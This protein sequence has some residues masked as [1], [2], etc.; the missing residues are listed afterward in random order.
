[1]DNDVAVFL[2]LDNILIG[3]IEVNLSFDIDLLLDHIKELTGGRLVLRRAYGDW[4]QRANMTKQLAASGF[5]L[6]STV[7]LGAN[8]KN[9][10]DMQMVVDA[11]STLVDG[12]DFSTYVLITGD[13]DF[14]PLVQAL[15]KRGKRVIGAGL[16]HATSQRLAQLCDEFIYYDQLAAEANEAL[17]GQLV[18]LIQRALDQLLQD[19]ERVPASLLRQRVQALSKGS[20]SR[21]PQGKRSFAK[22]LVD[23]PDVAHLEQE[24]T[25]LYVRRPIPGSSQALIEDRIAKHLPEEEVRELLRL[26][27][28]NLLR[29]HT[30]VRASL[31]KQQMQDLSN[32]AF[33]ETLQGDKSF[34]R[35][36]ERFPD[37]VRVEQ[38]GSTLYVRQTN[39]GDTSGPVAVGRIVSAS[40]AKNLLAQALDDLLVDQARVRA[41][42]LKQHMQELS[43]GAF[44]ENRLGN[45]TFRQFLDGYSDLVESQQKGTTLLV[46]RPQNYLKPDELHLRYRGALKKKGLRVVPSNIRLPLLKDI[47]A[48]LKRYPQLQWRLLVDQLTGYYLKSGQ[49]EISKSFV[50]DL[51]RVARRAGIINV[52]NGSSL[53]KSPVALQITG[54]RSFQDSVIKTDLVYLREIKNLSDPFDLEQAS[55]ALYEDV[56]HTRY[57]Q[58][59][60]NRFTDKSEEPS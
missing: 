15:R 58:V 22:L 60:L 51:L 2:D 20:F 31:L 13:R 19:Q 1:M 29:D 47:I 25:T 21:S 11:M 27:L 28:A 52:K 3:V 17:D 6:Q 14:A 38:E 43:D 42:L 44:D 53:A 23:F 9:L 12:Q 56:G 45:D 5:E 30:Q 57:L 24:G 35:F 50:N 54:E 49:E 46:Y 18:D 36:L 37:I 34:R 8:S 39:A 41:S 10:A 59:I 16:R 26:A 55:I 48:L 40:E 32:G 7:R 33:D 4:R